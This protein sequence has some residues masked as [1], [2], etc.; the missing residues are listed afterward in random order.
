MVPAC[1]GVGVSLQRDRVGTECAFFRRVSG[2]Q[3]AQA[4]LTLLASSEGD[5]GKLRDLRAMC[6]YMADAARYSGPGEGEFR[7]R[8]APAADAAKREIRA[9]ARRL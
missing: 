1:G 5:A 6:D 8:R 4:F 9:L 7:H 2:E 3:M